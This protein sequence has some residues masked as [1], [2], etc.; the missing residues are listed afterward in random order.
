MFSLARTPS[1][2]LSAALLALTLA[3]GSA[4][5]V[6]VRNDEIP[7]RTEP[8]PPSLKAV[9]D[10]VG[11]TEH[12]GAR[13][14]LDIALKDAD[15]RDVLIKDYFNQG[16]PVI[17]Q[18]GYFG[19][20]K[21]CGL[22]SEGLLGSLQKLDLEM[23]TQYDVLYVSIN[24]DENY[25]LAYQK[26]KTYAAEFGKPGV[27]QG[28]QFLTG[29][30]NNTK[31]I[32]DAVGFQYKY[33]EADNVYSHPAMI[34]II[35]PDGR[36]SRYMYGVDF[37]RTSLRLSLIEASDGKIGT[38]RDQLIMM[39]MHWDGSAG[40]Y[41]FVWVD[42]MRVGGGLTLLVLGFFLVRRYVRDAR[43]TTPDVAAA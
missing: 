35:T 2:R 43:T 27:Q 20:P 21:L 32:A 39:C 7:T 26:K 9:T 17:L 36:V 14:P 13:L 1:L 25:H 42:M 38:V 19:C 33:V 8:A 18:L 3:C 22:V 6:P 4:F 28:W 5:S 10:G 31:A 40:K 41:T 12:P 30:K 34:A 23:G 16:R 11:I 15:G 29:S 37:P 24:P